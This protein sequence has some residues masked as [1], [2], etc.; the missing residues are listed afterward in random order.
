MLTVYKA[1]AGSGKTFTL[2]IEYIKMLINNPMSYRNILAVTFTNKA[3][4]EMKSRIL[5][6]LYGMW[7]QLADSADYT[8]KISQD[9]GLAPAIVAERAGQALTLLVHHYN[10]FRV[11]TIDTFFQ[12]VLRNLARELDLTANMRIELGDTQ[13]EQQAV[14][15]MIENLRP[16]D[17][18]LVWIM[19]YITDTINDDKNW[20]VIRHIKDFGRNI[21][22]DFYKEHSDTLET[23]IGEATFFERYTSTLRTLAKNAEQRMKNVADEFFA[24]IDNAGFTIDDL[25]SK[26]RG[27]ASFFIKLQRGD[28]N[29]SAFNDKKTGELLATYRKALADPD[30]WLTKTALKGPNGTLLKALA[31]DKLTPLLEKAESTRRREWNNYQASQEVLAHM[32][33]LRLLGSIAQAVREDN[34][35]HNR[36]LL[37][38]T[39]YMLHRLIGHDDTPFIYEKIGTQINHIMIDEFQDTSTI[40]W[41]NFKVLL[42]ECL[43][44][45]DSGT[46]LIVGDVKQSIY[47][48]REGDW[49]LLNNIDAQFKDTPYTP[50][51]DSLKTNYRSE[52]NIIDF[53]N[54]FFTHAAMLERQRIADA[55]SDMMAAQLEKAYSDV[56]Q[57][58][59]ANRPRPKVGR[60]EVQLLPRQA[61]DE[62]DTTTL[63]MERVTATI[64]RLLSE[65]VRPRD[66]AVLMRRNED[67]RTIARY[68]SDH[69]PE[70][71]VVSGEAYRLDSSI[72]VNAIIWSL[73]LLLHPT[74][75]IMQANVACFYKKYVERREQ[76]EKKKRTGNEEEGFTCNEEKGFTGNEESF[77]SNETD[78]C[79]SFAITSAAAS[80][81][82][83]RLLFGD[84]DLSAL[85]LFEL[86]EHLQRLYKLDEIEGQSAFV[87]A[88]F[89]VINKFAIDNPSDIE[90]F[91]EQWDNS[92]CDL[93]I[94]TDDADGI[95]LLSIHKSKGLEYDNVIIPFCD[96]KMTLP[97]LIW[98]QPRTAPFNEL[99]LVAV[100]N[101]VSRM[102][103][104]CFEHDCLE[105]SFENIIDNLNMLYVAFT[106]AGKNLFVYGR[107]ADQQYRSNLLEQCL[108][109]IAADLEG[110][111]FEGAEGP[112]DEVRFAYG[113][114][115]KK[116]EKGKKGEKKEAGEEAG[117]EL[118]RLSATK[119]K[120]AN[121]FLAEK[122]HIDLDFNTYPSKATFRQSND[123]REFVKG[124]DEEQ[125]ISYIKKGNIMHGIFS[126]MRTADDLP[127]VMKSYVERGLLADAPITPEA[128]TSLM[129][130]RLACRQAA[131]WFAP[132]W[133]LYNECTI[134]TR[135]PNDPNKMKEYRPDRVM[136]RNGRFVVVDFKF[137]SPTDE[138]KQQVGLYMAMLKQMGHNDVEGYLWYVYPNRVVKC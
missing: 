33:Q 51:E 106:R 113:T 122:E 78:G 27:A 26:S 97:G 52:R 57:L 4:D 56:V 82:A 70:V 15:R 34:I 47:R 79:K 71:P 31:H 3:T 73:R 131:D 2:T 40:Q 130:N 83:D 41:A 8:S 53:N 119:P 138:H 115:A 62:T 120:Q 14:D 132:G 36:F 84:T 111:E 107:R 87:C 5:T 136:E 123:S 61:D 29:P 38:D 74:D 45:E 20:N 12:I 135:D 7:K 11:V 86:A 32:H 65:H 96:W 105:E 99:P 89:D 91:L 76:D 116:G 92:Y 28:Y 134:L 1:S 66:I 60:I 64:S 72:A 23:T 63:M 37:S 19:Q 93:T 50:H 100:S 10:H 39:Q 44:R 58:I 104:T 22:K 81:I 98:C 77:V 94:Q 43:S 25:A 18:L 109:L 110:A 6:K 55:G 9:L 68:L 90:G 35:Q 112:D 24:A 102:A 17:E 127:K 16:T 128:I 129:S 69:L 108:P 101:I 80:Q 114:I 42:L 125:Q 30:A 54:S 126:E 46:N 121:V 21:F 137:A 85:P 13:I 48:W 95:Q 49:R 117:E 103:G 118:S 59:P 88:F 133:R 67:V 75:E 124:E